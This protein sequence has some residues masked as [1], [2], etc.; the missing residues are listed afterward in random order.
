MGDRNLFKFQVLGILLFH[1]SAWLFSM[2]LVQIRCCGLFS[3]T[4]VIQVE[5]INSSHSARPSAVTLI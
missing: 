3:V 2:G 5:V 4:G 1:Y